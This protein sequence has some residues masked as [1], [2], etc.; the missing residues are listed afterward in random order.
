MKK[1]M[2]VIFL[3]FSA[4]GAYAYSDMDTYDT[5]NPLFLERGGDVLSVTGVDYGKDV[6]ALLQKVSVGLNGKLSLSGQI[7]WQHDF[8]GS[9]DG[10][11]YSGLGV[12][13][14]FS[15]SG[16][17]ADFI[18]DV[19]FGGRARVPEYADTVYSVGVRAGRQWN[20]IALAGTLETHWIFDDIYGMAYVD[21]T[22]EIYIHAWKDWFMGAD[23]KIRKATTPAYDAEWIG[24]KVVKQY[25]RT[26]YTGFGRY[27]FEREEFHAGLRV[28]ILF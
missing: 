15:D 5:E 3:S 7:N 9:E 26:M 1:L 18:A 16:V 19:K 24:G 25:G 4:T 17:I 8:N 27:E 20:R 13:Y 22:P 2:A 28:N 23:V 21:L 6:L 10:F 12:A 14:R 11:T